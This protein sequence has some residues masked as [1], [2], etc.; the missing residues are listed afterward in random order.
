MCRRVCEGAD[1]GSGDILLVDPCL[2]RGDGEQAVKDSARE[3]IFEGLHRRGF[4][5][6]SMVFNGFQWI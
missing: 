6:F 3:L 5:W 1:P 4:E 2:L